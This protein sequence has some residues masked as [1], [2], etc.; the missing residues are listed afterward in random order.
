MPVL[1][2]HLFLERTPRCKCKSFK[3]FLVQHPIVSHSVLTHLIR[4]ILQCTR[5]HPRKKSRSKQIIMITFNAD[6]TAGGWEEPKNEKYRKSLSHQYSPEP[7]KLWINAMY[8]I[9]VISASL[10]MLS[11]ALKEGAASQFDPKNEYSTKSWHSDRCCHPRHNGHLIL[12]LNLILA[13]NF[14]EEEKVMYNIKTHQIWLMLNEIYRRQKPITRPFI[15]IA[16]RRDY[17]RSSW[18]DI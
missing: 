3:H 7:T 9:P 12:I 8:E 6:Y 1:L 5:Q 14:V 18:Y 2:P 16:R 11:L 10:F 13:Y 17:V 15:S 4:S